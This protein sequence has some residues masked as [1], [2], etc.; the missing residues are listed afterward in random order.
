VIA[1]LVVK[2]VVGLID[3]ARAQVLFAI[4][5]ELLEFGDFNDVLL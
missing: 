5:L 1:A 2:G 3:T 4:K